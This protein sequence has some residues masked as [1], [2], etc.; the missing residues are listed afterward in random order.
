MPGSRIVELRWNSILND[1]RRS[2]L[3]QAEFCRRRNISL[4]SFRYQFYKR[5]SSKPCPSDNL[6]SAGGARTGAGRGSSPRINVIPW[7]SALDGI[8]GSVYT[9]RIFRG[10]SAMTIARGQLIG[11][12][13]TRWYHCMSRCVRGALLLCEGPSDRKAWIENRIEELAQI[14]AV[15]VGGFSVM[16]NIEDRRRFDS[17][18]EGM[19][20]GLSIGNY[21]LLVDFTGRSFAWERP[22]FRQSWLEFSTGLAAVRSAGNSGWKSVELQ[23]IGPGQ[24][25]LHAAMACTRL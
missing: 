15:G 18:R 10:D 9:M 17:P 5:R 11:V 8:S 1:F 12:S 16:D 13:V 23:E 4:A 19:F 20:E 14:F 6:A 24:I 3:T 2:G 25:R 21:L 7:R 22:R